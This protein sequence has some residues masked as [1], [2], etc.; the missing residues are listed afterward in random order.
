MT[1]HLLAIDQGTS[2]TKCVL[3]D[4]RGRI[5]AKAA[6][7][8]GERYPQPGWVEQDAA[9][10]WTSVREAVQ[11]CLAQAGGVRVA[12]VG[13]STQRESALVWDRQTGQAITPVL[14]WQ[15]Q[16][17]VARRRTCSSAPACRWTRCSRR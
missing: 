16:R 1:A 7:A 17:T 8:L 13:L 6:A 9:E 5:V 12:A 2:A 14:S 10:I 15:D 4:D 11:A 3:V